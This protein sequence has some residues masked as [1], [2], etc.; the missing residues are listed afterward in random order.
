MISLSHI[1]ATLP[2]GMQQTRASTNMLFLQEKM[3][4]AS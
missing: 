2:K 3:D 4:G 1:H